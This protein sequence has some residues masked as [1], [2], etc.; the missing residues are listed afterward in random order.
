MSAKT[1]AIRIVEQAHIP[2]REAFYA[3][4]EKDLSGIHAANA[5]NM[6]EWQ[7]FKTLVIAKYRESTT[8]E[9]MPPDFERKHNGS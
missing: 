9:V 4:D 7:V 8:I 5:I 2:C 6:D 1:N 3:F